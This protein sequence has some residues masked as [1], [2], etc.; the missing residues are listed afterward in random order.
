MKLQIYD[1]GKQM[2]IKKMLISKCILII[3]LLPI[4]ALSGCSKSKLLIKDKNLE[5]L[6]RNEIN[7]PK[8]KLTDEDLS[9]IQELTINLSDVNSLE[10]INH[11]TNLEGLHI[12]NI[13][14]KISTKTLD[15]APIKD[16]QKI[17]YISLNNV[18]VKNL[19]ELKDLQNLTTID[20][21]GTGRDYADLKEFKYL[22]EVYINVSNKTKNVETL[23]KLSSLRSLNVTE[24]ESGDITFLIGFTT[25]TNL[26]I[27]D[28]IINDTAPI[29]QLKN[30]L[31]VDLVN[32]DVK[33]DTGLD[34]ISSSKEINLANTKMPEKSLL[35]K[36]AGIFKSN[37]FETNI[38]YFD[39][40]NES[41]G[42]V[43]SALKYGKAILKLDYKNAANTFFENTKGEII[44]NAVSS[45]V[46]SLGLPL[47][48]VAGV[49]GVI[50]L[51]GYLSRGVKYS[52]RFNKRR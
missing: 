9:S 34:S 45:G 10:G 32:C 44:S 2:K 12:S 24:I 15:L 42:N 22:K 39:T 28:S 8:G 51:Y 49:A 30:L 29:A 36:V 38:H 5:L 13:N 47:V 21:R 6:V 23:T 1:R 40:I 33:K 20:Y 26:Q 27:R 18:K 31:V 37:D 7:K 48:G 50:G 43:D 11:I 3:M 16:L 14:S 35:K 41:I 17:R 52:H 19:N 4:L 25:I 46:S